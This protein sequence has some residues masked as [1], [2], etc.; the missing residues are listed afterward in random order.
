MAGRISARLIIFSSTRAPVGTRLHSISGSRPASSSLRFARR[1]TPP[2][3][4]TSGPALILADEA[5]SALSRA[6]QR[7]RPLGPRSLMSLS[8]DD[9][10]ETV[11]VP[12]AKL[13]FVRSNDPRGPG[14]SHIQRKLARAAIIIAT[15]LEDSIILLPVRRAISFSPT[16]C[17]RPVDSRNPLKMAKPLGNHYTPTLICAGV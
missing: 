4:S 5:L 13:Q 17:E 16:P 1:F 6:R 12:S 10:G 15:A 2:P 9:V 8:R 14:I 11:P 7:S 3:F